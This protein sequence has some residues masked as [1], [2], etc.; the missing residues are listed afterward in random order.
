MQDVLLAFLGN[1]RPVA[2]PDGITKS[3]PDFEI[4]EMRSR[5]AKDM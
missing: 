1:A 4:K 2:A 3:N 5:N